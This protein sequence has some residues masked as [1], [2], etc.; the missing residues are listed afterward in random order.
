VTLLAWFAGTI[1]WLCG[2]HKDKNLV[3]EDKESGQ[4][5][6]SPTGEVGYGYPKEHFGLKTHKLRSPL[7]YLKLL[8]FYSILGAGTLCSGNQPRLMRISL[9]SKFYE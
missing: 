1:T 6:P 3:E 2:N 8:T 5:A 4:Q 7:L 9:A